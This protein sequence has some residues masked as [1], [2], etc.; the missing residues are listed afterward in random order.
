[1]TERTNGLADLAT[2]AADGRAALADGAQTIRG[3]GA[4]LGRSAIDALDSGREAVARGFGRA[5]DTLH[6]GGDT[7]AAQGTNAG[8]MA[9][10]A[11]DK[12]ASAA[13]YVRAH[14]TADIWDDLTGLVRVHPGKSLL[15]AL[16]VGY[17]AGL[18][19]QRD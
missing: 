1:M 4:E 6:D 16:A 15:A 11:A 13:K 10:G 2:A 9:H 5:A 18:A 19:L 7:L 14:K 3:K 8:N 12:M 17:L